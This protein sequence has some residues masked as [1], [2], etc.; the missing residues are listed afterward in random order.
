MFVYRTHGVVAA[1]VALLLTA[2]ACTD[3]TERSDLR[4]GGIPGPPAVLVESPDPR[5]NP[6]NLEVATFCKLN[7]VKR[8]GIVGLLDTSTYTVCPLDLTMGAPEVTNAD[9]TLWYVRLMFDELL[10]PSVEDLVPIIDPTTMLPNGTYNG[11]LANTQ[12]VT[13]QCEDAAGALQ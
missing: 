5:G 9:P 12:P 3:P 7:D 4:T 2:G 11:T 6:G 1:G 13:L 10:D 8:P